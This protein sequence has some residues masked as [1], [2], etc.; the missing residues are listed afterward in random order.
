MYAIRSYYV[1]GQQASHI[2]RANL[3]TTFIDQLLRAPPE[4]PLPERIFV[5][6][7]STLPPHY[8]AALQALGQRMEVHFMLTN[9]CRHYWGDLIEDWRL[10]QGWLRQLLARRRT[11]LAA[12]SLTAD[13][14]NFV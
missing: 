11:H 12:G 5:F 7:I 6:G 14:N 4:Q 3:F 2:H 9:P 8:L 13:R 1:T 10:D